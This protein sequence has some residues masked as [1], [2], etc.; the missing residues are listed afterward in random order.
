MCAVHISSRVC[1]LFE[2]FAKT[3]NNFNDNLYFAAAPYWFRIGC[4][5]PLINIISQNAAVYLC[6]ELSNKKCRINVQLHSC[7]LTA[8][9]VVST[10][11]WIL[12]N[13]INQSEDEWVNQN[14]SDTDL[15]WRKKSS[16]LRGRKPSEARP[17]W[18]SE[19]MSKRE[20]ADENRMWCLSVI[21]VDSGRVSNYFRWNCSVHS[22]PRFAQSNSE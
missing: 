6:S 11:G 4:I 13:I 22:R 14:I 1:Y 2:C 10:A 8:V 21:T 9:G 3:Q 18:C 12:W 19:H 5:P 16:H 15:A 20:G 17:K 7:G